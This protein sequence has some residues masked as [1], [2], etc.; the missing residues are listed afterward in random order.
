[1]THQKKRLEKL[2]LSESEEDIDL[3]VT[4]HDIATVVSQ[5]TG[6]PVQQMEQKESDRLLKL[7]E[8]LHQ[9]VIGQKAAVTAVS[10][11]IRRARSGLKD[12]NRPIG[13]FMFLGP[14]GVGKTELAKSL[15]ESIFGSEDALV[16]VDMS[17]YMEKH[18][19]SRLVGSPPGYVGY[20][21]GGQLTEAVRR[22]PYSVV[23][24]DEIEK[25][26]P[27]VFNMLLQILDDGRLT[28]SKGKTVDFKN[29][30]IIMTSNVGATSLRKQNTLGFATT[31]DV[32]KEE[33]EKMK[34]TITEELK[35][36]FRPEFLNRLDDTIVFHSL[37]EEHV[38]EIV[39]I[40]INDLEKRLS[41]LEVNV[42]ISE[43]TKEYIA[44]QGFDP[45]YGARPL[46]RTIRKM[47]E[48]QLAEEILRGTVSKEGKILI[49]YEDD[50]L[51]FK[52]AANV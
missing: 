2:L 7:E 13:S 20:D 19:T 38:K 1:M 33:Y 35:R 43:N 45:I 27:D 47:I 5:W 46:E 49:D 41:K 10:R 4:E 36:T 48:D 6:I 44:K 34:E 22:K 42:E 17:E 40:M 11:A 24:F 31:L 28:D 32:K 21:E 52:K 29:T 12:P 8:E 37:K 26:H 9:R 25:A 39:E 23:L 51:T 18:S 14:T 30:V 50:K 15:A 16:R 3:E